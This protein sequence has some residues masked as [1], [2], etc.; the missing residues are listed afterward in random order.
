LDLPPQN[1]QFTGRQKELQQLSDIVADAG[2]DQCKIAVLHGLGGMGKTSIVLH[3]AWQNYTRYSAIIWIHAATV[4]MLR[5]SF[6]HVAEALIQHLAVNYG[7]AGPGYIQIASRLGIPGLINASGQLMYN[8]ESN[9]QDKII[10][11]VSKWLATNG[12]DN[13]LLIFDNMDD[14]EVVDQAKHFPRCSSGTIIITSRRRG[15]AQWGESLHIDGMD[16]KGALD[17]LMK[18]SKLDWNQLSTIGNLQHII[19]VNLLIH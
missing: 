14:L 12:N 4:E 6:I 3:Y 13:W 9:D 1:M 18:R 8:A 5:S 7:S 10:N 11:A 17:L 16:E 19:C 2:R 15:I